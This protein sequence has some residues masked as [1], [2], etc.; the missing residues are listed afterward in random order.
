[1]GEGGGVFTSLWLIN[2]LNCI[3]NVKMPQ[4]QKLSSTR[5]GWGEEINSLVSL[6]RYE[7]NLVIL[8]HVFIDVYRSNMMIYRAWGYL[9]VSS[10]K[11]NST[12][13]S[14]LMNRDKYY[15]P[16]TLPSDVE[17]L[18]KLLWLSKNIGSKLWYNILKDNCDTTE[19]FKVQHLTI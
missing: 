10:L 18:G 8:L 11:Y 5:S 13:I 7:I 4:K 15:E 12:Y 6:K 16:G 9:W 3:Y 1:M 19:S 17:I 14:I 2:S